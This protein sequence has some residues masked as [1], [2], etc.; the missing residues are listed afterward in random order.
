MFIWQPLFGDV[1]RS[2]FVRSPTRSR[3]LALQPGVVGSEQ[4]PAIRAN[5]RTL[6]GTL[7]FSRCRSWCSCV[8]FRIVVRSVPI[9]R[10]RIAGRYLEGRRRG[11]PKKLE[12]SGRTV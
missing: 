5:A 10:V 2:L 3:V 7:G 6:G 8:V 12:Q 4:G 11:F 1:A 9:D